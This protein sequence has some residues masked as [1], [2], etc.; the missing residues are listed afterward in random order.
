LVI[1]SFSPLIGSS[2][3]QHKDVG[4]FAASRTNALRPRFQFPIG[5]P[6]QSAVLAERR[7][8]ITSRLKD[9]S[10]RNLSDHA[11]AERRGP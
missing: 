4:V 10:I 8:G 1:G 3:L 6:D 9:Q 5:I 2:E 7:N 11:S